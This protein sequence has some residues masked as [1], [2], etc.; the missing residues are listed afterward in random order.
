MYTHMCMST[1]LQIDLLLLLQILVKYPNRSHI[2][3][4]SLLTHGNVWQLFNSK[5]HHS[6]RLPFSLSY[7]LHSPHPYKYIMLAIIMILI[8]LFLCFCLEIVNFGAT[9]NVD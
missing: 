5:D 9:I 7:D 8:S 1:H 6:V 4:V 3:F 2:L